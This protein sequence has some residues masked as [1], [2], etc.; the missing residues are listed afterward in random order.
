MQKVSPKDSR[1][2]ML[3]RKKHALF[4]QG[5]PAVCQSRSR[6]WGS[7][8]KALRGIGESAVFA[9]YL[10]ENHGGDIGAAAERCAVLPSFPP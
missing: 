2:E 9:E 6:V 4:S 10:A 7:F 8:F 3:P 1:A 5:Y